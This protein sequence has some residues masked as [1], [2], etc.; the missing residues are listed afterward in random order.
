MGVFDGVH[1][2]HKE[3]LKVTVAQ[4]RKIRGTSIAVTF[5]PHPQKEESLY[6]L[7]HRLRFIAELG[8]D[9]CIVI[10][11]SRHFA[12]IKARDFVKDILVDKICAGH[13]YVGRN[14]RFGK[15][16]KGDFVLLNNLGKIYGF[17][18]RGFKIIKAQ[19]KPISSTLIR[20]LI[21]RGKIKEAQR[22]LGRSVSILG[23]VI[24][25]A[26][27][28]RMLGFSTA[29]IDPHHEVIPAAGTYAARIILG[30]NK[31]KGACYIGRRPTISSQFTIHSSQKKINVE[32]HMFKFNK[33]IYG[34]CL[35]IQFVKRIR[36]DKKFANLA[37]LSKQIKKDVS[38][39][40][41][42]LN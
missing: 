25:G 15:N 19:G 22:L 34:K 20:N 23:T 3:I 4:A 28:G 9:V 1:R 36:L 41:K 42:I 26:A 35:E 18:A 5:W 32:V 33:N 37:S 38:T 14:F 40:K 27:L 16:I 8:I 17:K 39:V 30:H 2:G 29:N 10:N 13:I 12:K 21:R 11:F 24:K 7:E 31:L 6:S